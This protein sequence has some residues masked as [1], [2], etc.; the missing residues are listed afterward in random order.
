MQNPLVRASATGLP[1][2]THRVFRAGSFALAASSLA[3][4]PT[5]AARED[6]VRADYLQ[7]RRA[8]EAYHREC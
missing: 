3:T 2:A 6:A 1:N 7:T 8:R 4:V 5:L